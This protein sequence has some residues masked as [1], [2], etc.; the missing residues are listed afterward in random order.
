MARNAKKMFSQTLV[1][2]AASA[3][4]AEPATD[5]ET[6]RAAVNESLG[7]VIGAPMLE[8]LNVAKRARKSSKAS[9]ANVVPPKVLAKKVNEHEAKKAEALVARGVEVASQIIQHAANEAKGWKGFCE[10]IITMAKESRAAM[11]L[12]M[13]KVRTSVTNAKG[14]L[15]KLNEENFTSGIT[16]ETLRTT[17]R[18]AYQRISELVNFS[19]A[20]DDGLDSTGAIEKEYKRV[21]NAPARYA[22][23]S[24][25]Q[26]IAMGREFRT[27][28]AVEKG[29]TPTQRAKKVSPEKRIRM[30]LLRMVA[31]NVVSPGAF[32]AHIVALATD[33]AKS[34]GSAK[35]AA[36]ILALEQKTAGTAHKKAAAKAA[37]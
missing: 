1:Q 4:T 32:K 12:N 13:G 15:V 22:D 20:V 3:A 19:R 27:R 21:F 37:A 11:R 28:L 35:H 24:Y 6:V 5:A 34:I 17:N 18:S 14:E 16:L 7:R 36:K 25:H 33:L 8:S 10:T 30:A 23:M 26:I 31:N 2:S 29:E 9:L